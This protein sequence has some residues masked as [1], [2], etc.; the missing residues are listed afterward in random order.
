[1][2]TLTEQFYDVMYKYRKSFGI[3]GVQKN[4]EQWKAGKKDLHALLQKHPD[5]NEDEMAVVLHYEDIRDIDRSCVDEGVFEMTQLAKDC[6]LCGELFDNFT[7]A[8]DAATRDYRRVPNESRLSDIRRLGGIECAPGQKASRIVNRLCLKFGLDRYVVDK[9]ES[10]PDG[11]KTM[12]QIHPYNAI[13]ARLADALNPGVEQRVG[14]LSI[15]P[16]DF[17]EMSNKDNSWHSCHCLEDGGYQAGA[18]SYMGDTVTMIFYMVA[19]DV[20]REFHKA[21]RIT[22]EVFCYY[23]GTLLQSRLYPT[24]RADQRERYMDLVERVITTCLDV[25]NQWITQAITH[26]T[27]KYWLTDRNALHYRDYNNGYAVVSLLQGQEF[28]HKIFVIGSQAYCVCCGQELYYEDRLKCSSCRGTIICKECGR[29]VG[30]AYGEY[31]D[32]ASAFFCGDCRPRCR[33]CSTLIQGEVYRVQRHRH[34]LTAN[35]CRTCY[36]ELTEACRQCQCTS[37]CEAVDAAVFCGHSE[38]FPEAA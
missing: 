36:E 17:L 9:E 20:E 38:W 24:D 6:G 33:F 11:T 14:V 29:E 25:P 1:M 34:G 23:D 8:L 35:A 15:H 32:E 4:L 27:D 22:R 13:F 3:A 21:P 18:L 16:C 26:S 19:S 5:W 10:S 2:N 12:R 37:V 31:D 28:Q 7:G 30:T